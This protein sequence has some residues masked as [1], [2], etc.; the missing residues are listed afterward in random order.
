MVSF[1]LKGRTAEPIFKLPKLMKFLV[2]AMPE[3]NRRLLE[4]VRQAKN[5]ASAVDAPVQETP[6]AREMTVCQAVEDRIC[7][8]I[9]LASRDDLTEREVMAA[10]CLIL[11]IVRTTGWPFRFSVAE[12]LLLMRRREASSGSRPTGGICLASSSKPAR[13]RPSS[14]PFS[15]GMS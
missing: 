3:L 10:L 11:K 8:R 13:R 14:S 12:F 7:K 15:R 2:S 1:L 9:D 5:S 6:E 4:K